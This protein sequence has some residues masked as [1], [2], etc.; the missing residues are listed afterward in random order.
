M[1]IDVK[2]IES[3]VAMIPHSPVIGGQ[4]AHNRFF[5]VEK[6]GFDIALI[7]GSEE[8][9]SGNGNIVDGEVHRFVQ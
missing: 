7:A 6:P 5:L 9:M 2:I 8:D 4:E 3:I 1:F